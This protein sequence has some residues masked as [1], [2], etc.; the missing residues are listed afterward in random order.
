VDALKSRLLKE[1]QQDLNVKVLDSLAWG[2][3]MHTVEITFKTVLR[4]KMDI[5]MKMMLITF[6][7]STTAT[8]EELSDILL[9]E[10]LFIQDLIG[11]MTRGNLI[12]ASSGGFS[13]TAAGV[14][15]LETGI[16]EHE[17]ESESLEMLYSPCHER[18]LK[19]ELK[20]KDIVSQEIYR[21]ASDFNDWDS[22]FFEENDLLNAVK[23]MDVESVEGNVQKVVAEIGSATELQLDLVPVLEFHLFNKTEDILYARVW[24]TLLGHWDEV[25]EAQL[26]EREVKMWREKY[27]KTN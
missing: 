11:I 15:Q 2:L 1:L 6:Q 12:E 10:P 18:F 17:A 4:T 26:N 25:L 16:F 23:S 27:V 21:Y 19:G 22:T 9:V 7:K 5:L 24:N 13:L 3:P 20:E 14:H 8:A